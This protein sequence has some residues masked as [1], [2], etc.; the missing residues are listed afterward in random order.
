VRWTIADM[1]R[2]TSTA[3]LAVMLVTSTV[4]L[5]LA[6]AAAPAG[7]AR[8]P[9]PPAPAGTFRLP[10]AGTAE[11]D[12][13][14]ERPPTRWAAGH[15]GVDLRAP[16]GADVLAPVAGVVT[17]AGTV[18][19]R[20]VVT[21]TDTEGRRSS[22]EPLVPAVHVGEL[23]TVGARLGTLTVEGSH[24]APSTCLHW[25]VR[26]GDDYVDPL[27]LLAGAGPVVLLP[28]DSVR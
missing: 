25:G 20:P 28:L 18:G 19:G 16:L 4:L 9:G 14:F 23:V 17:F 2:G 7:S 13:A 22:V 15:R 3:R 12:R 5:A 27:R 11:V 21:V 10:L 6:V 24:C 26:V 8:A 1:T